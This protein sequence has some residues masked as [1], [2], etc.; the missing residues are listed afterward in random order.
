MM[1]KELS[2]IIE[3]KKNIFIYFILLFYLLIFSIINLIIIISF[4]FLL[5]IFVKLNNN[6]LN[7]F[8]IT[9]AQKNQLLS[10]II[11]F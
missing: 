8:I 11:I 3:I 1:E 2:L 4:L 9:F 7:Y 6:S 10:I 5:F